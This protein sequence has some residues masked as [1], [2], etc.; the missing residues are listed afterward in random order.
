MKL[1]KQVVEK[2]GR[3]DREILREDV[4]EGVEGVV[5]GR[6]EPLGGDGQ[7]L[8]ILRGAAVM[9]LLLLQLHRVKYPE[10]N[11]RRNNTLLERAVS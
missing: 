2:E 9:V 10:K 6:V 4:G 5:A 7:P 8:C 1:G 11:L 3:D